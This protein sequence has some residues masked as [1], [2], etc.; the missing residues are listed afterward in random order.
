MGWRRRS[1]LWGALLIAAGVLLLLKETTD[2]FEPVSP[3]PV[4]LAVIGLWLAVE[5]LSVGDRRGFAVPLVLVGVGVF[6]LLR[7]TDAISASVSV[8][9]VILIALGAAVLLSLLPG[10]RRARQRDDE[11]QVPPPATDRPEPQG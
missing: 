11:G 3:W 5:R 4:V 2:R 1:V 9:P 8:W 10:G 6:Y 7:E